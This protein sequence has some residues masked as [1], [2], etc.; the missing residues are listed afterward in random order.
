MAI[1]EQTLKTLQSDMVVNAEWRKKKASLSQIQ[2]QTLSSLDD[3][4]NPPATPNQMPSPQ[5]LPPTKVELPPITPAD[6]PSDDNSSS[7][8]DNSKKGKARKSSKKKRRKSRKKQKKKGYSSSS[9]SDSESDSDTSIAND[10][11][12]RKILRDLTRTA[13][14]YKIKELTM[15]TDPNLR[16]E[17]F[18][19][20]VIDARN[21]LSTNSKTMGLL[22][23]YLAELPEFTYN[24]DRAI[25]ALLSSITQGM[26]K[27]L[28]SNATSAHQAL[29][30]LRRNYAQT[31][32]FDIH[33]ERVKMMMM[34]QGQ[35][36]KAS[37][38]LR[39]IRKQIA[40]CTNV[41]CL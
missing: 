2:E 6:D 16:R 24:V 1:K 28:V 3:T 11:L 27:Q 35:S 25:K 5:Q 33:Q 20:W 32:R 34:K 17:R 15:S 40:V 39:R 37:E 36:E 8:S 10:N 31:S 19:T 12:Y 26:A 18:N 4:F 13:K 21:I 14:N 41:G 38:F 30:D 9:G 7:S 22:D 29:L 23:W